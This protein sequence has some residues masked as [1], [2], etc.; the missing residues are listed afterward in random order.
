MG[1]EKGSLQNLFLAVSP[2]PTIRYQI[3]NLRNGANARL[4]GRAGNKRMNLYKSRKW[5][6]P[7]YK[8][9]AWPVCLLEYTPG[10]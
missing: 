8:I 2:S 9:A 6:N 5:L 4:T 1:G 3:N 10:Y 7:L